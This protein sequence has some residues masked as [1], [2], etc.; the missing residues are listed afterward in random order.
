MFDYIQIETP[1]PIPDKYKEE[2]KDIKWENG[3][4]VTSSMNAP[5]LDKYTIS[6]N[7]KIYLEKV[8]YA[9][10]ADGSVSGIKY[11][12]IEEVEYT[13]EILMSSKMHSEEQDATISLKAY[14]YK[15]L[16]QELVFVNFTRQDNRIRKAAE[17][18]IKKR[19][20][21]SETLK[22]KWWYGSYLKYLMV[23]DLLFFVV[24]YSLGVLMKISFIIQ[25][26]IT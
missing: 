9:Q 4:F 11:K 8:E 13:G 3:E 21:E 2:L 20:E 14:F 23:T 1:L 25:R 10:D 6:T 12:G 24:R 26:K 5:S 16:L 17:E 7:K 18:K 22:R 15:G 19:I